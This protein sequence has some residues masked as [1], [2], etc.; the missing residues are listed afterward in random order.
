M[1]KC[2]LQVLWNMS[3]MMIKD[4]KVCISC[5]SSQE[6]KLRSKSIH[7]MA[8]NHDVSTCSDRSSVDCSLSELAL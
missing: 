8:W 4:Y 6:A 2:L 1:V 3:L 5:F 7:L